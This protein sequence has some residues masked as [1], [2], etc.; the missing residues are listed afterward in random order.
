VAL[1]CAAVCAA[2]FAV[3]AW[4]VL[5]R[6]G[7]PYAVDTGPHRW[8]VEHRPHA[9][10]ETARVVTDAGTGPYPYA[11]AALGGWLAG[12]RTLRHGTQTAVLALAALL[13]GQAVRTVLMLT[14]DRTRPPVADWAAHASG[15]SFPSGHTTSSALAAGLLAWGLLRAFPG[16][17]GRVLTA[18]CG[19]VAA[20]IG[21]TRVYLGVHWPTDVLAGWLF[22]ACWLGALLPPLTYF[23]KAGPAPPGRQE[24]ATPPGREAP[25]DWRSPESREAPDDPGGPGRPAGAG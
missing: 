8:S 18:V 19:L 7:T 23:A 16:A 6:H 24:Q 20:A 4:I 11:A 1:A 5:A 15:H 13:A 2:A 3:L 25:D 17:G 14:L 22:A 10:A 12:G 21:C 9:M